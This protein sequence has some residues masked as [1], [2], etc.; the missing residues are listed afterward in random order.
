MFLTILGSG[1]ILY[2]CVYLY[3]QKRKRKPFE[4]NRNIDT[5]IETDNYIDKLNLCQNFERFGIVGIIL[6][7]F[8]AVPRFQRYMDHF[9]D[10]I[11]EIHGSIMMEL[12]YYLKYDNKNFYREFIHDWNGYKFN[13][14]IMYIS[15]V[16][17]NESENT[18]SFKRLNYIIS[19]DRKFEIILMI[20][21]N[22]KQ[23]TIPVKYHKQKLILYHHEYELNCCICHMNNEN[24]SIVLENQ[25]FKPKKRIFNSKIED[26]E[27]D[28]E[29]YIEILVF[30]R[31][32][33]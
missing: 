27:S 28:Y 1:M 4:I 22:S 32:N 13:I 21:D 16:V 18:I 24:H 19:S 8:F 5:L 26:V 10:R 20:S 3:A 29:N 9:H 2:G 30:E 23:L 14:L 15:E 33:A 12:N 7:A 6:Q 17:I 11:G 25:Y 31:Q